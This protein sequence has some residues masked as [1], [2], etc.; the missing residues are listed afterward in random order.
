MG[1]VTVSAGCELPSNLP[2]HPAGAGKPWFA[3]VTQVVSPVPCMA[4]GVMLR[5][6]WHGW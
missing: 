2:A 1:I 5:P 6:V 4:Q 3:G